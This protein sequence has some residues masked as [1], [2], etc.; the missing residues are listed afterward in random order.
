ML[1]IV[2][3]TALAS[4]DSFICFRGLLVLGPTSCALRTVGTKCG[5]APGHFKNYGERARMIA[6]MNRSISK[7]K[8]Y[9]KKKSM[10]MND[11]FPVAP[12]IHMKI[13]HSDKK[14]SKTEYSQVSRGVRNQVRR[15]R[16]PLSSCSPIDAT[17]YLRTVL[18]NYEGHEFPI[19]V[20]R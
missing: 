15:G 11:M 5:L 16:R 13:A 14:K 6:H 10:K 20:S 3:S 7:K 9:K 17:P 19:L 18:P 2:V 12:C 1:I 8:Y 4:W